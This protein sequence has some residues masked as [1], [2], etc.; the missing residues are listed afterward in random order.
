MPM[1]ADELKGAKSLEAKQMIVILLTDIVDYSPKTAS[2]FL[3]I[4]MSALLEGSGSSHP[5]LRHCSCFGI[6]VVAQKVG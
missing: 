3:D 4:I 5:G 2:K 1:L 6:G